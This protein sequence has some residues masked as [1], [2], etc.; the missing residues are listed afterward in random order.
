MKK[1]KDAYKETPN[2]IINLYKEGDIE[3]L[4][5]ISHTIKGIAATLGAFELSQSAENLEHTLR[6]SDDAD[7][8]D[9]VQ[10]LSRNLHAIIEELE[11]I[12]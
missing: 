8:E 10:L 1:F 9:I 2:E 4:Y 11:V 3:K 7:V 6:D 5:I 12:E